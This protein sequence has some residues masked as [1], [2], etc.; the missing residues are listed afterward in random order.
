MM[1]L[2]GQIFLR[3]GNGKK[4]HIGSAILGDGE[5]ICR[6][7]GSSLEI[8]ENIGKE[9]RGKDIC[10]RCVLL[11]NHG[12]RAWTPNALAGRGGLSFGGIGSLRGE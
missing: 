12:R 2:Y 7:R 1:E 9:Y 6:G 3:I 4:V 8:T 5:T 11:Y 10:K